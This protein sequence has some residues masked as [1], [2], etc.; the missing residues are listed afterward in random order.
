MARH[1]RTVAVVLATLAA[2][3]AASTGLVVLRGMSSGGADGGSWTGTCAGSAEL[4]DR[5]LDQVAFATTHNSMNA[6]ADGFGYP[7][8]QSGIAAQLAAGV[9]GF[10]VDAYLGSVRSVD[11]KQVV[12]TDIT[13]TSR[14]NLLVQATHK[15]SVRRAVDLRRRAGAPS[16][17]A[18][19]Q[20]YLCHQFCEL[21]AQSMT[22]VVATWRR[23]LDEHPDEVLVIVIQ[24][25]M[26]AEPLRDALDDLAP[27]LATL[28][29]A[30]PLPTLGEMLASGR[31]AVVGLE[32]GDLGPDLPNVFTDGLVQEVPYTYRRTSSLESPLS[33]RR[34]RGSTSAPLFLLN[35]WI[36]PAS[37]S[38]AASVNEADVLGDRI[39][40][41]ARLRRQPVNLVAVDFYE[42]G[43]LLPV[44]A[45]LN[46]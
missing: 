31:R 16:D 32:N 6:A 25:E 33:C 35:H 15:E 13:T 10:L 18:P 4:C 21:G 36:T 5:R 3:A 42:S 29:P 11:G 1:R 22:S 19:R 9:R 23:F 41:C 43:D 40:M 34:H 30:K 44:V 20:V 2:L 46:E 7:D 37:E 27:Y 12:Y 24:D 38:A 14:A 39:D 28:D 17:D 45:A 8:Q 26:P